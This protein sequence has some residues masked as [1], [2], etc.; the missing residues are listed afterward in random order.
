MYNIY[1]IATLL[2]NQP[3]YKPIRRR[4][5]TTSLASKTMD[6]PSI[7]PKGMYNT[8]YCAL[9]DNIILYLETSSDLSSSHSPLLGDN[10]EID[11]NLF[12]SGY[13]PLQDFIDDVL[14]NQSLPNYD[15]GKLFSWQKKKPRKN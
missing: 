9:I 10:M 5:K 13:N 14:L 15:T 8:C 6:L 2:S 11:D 3:G 4:K 1:I 7:S 12:Q